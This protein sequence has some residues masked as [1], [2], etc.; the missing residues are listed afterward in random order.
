VDNVLAAHHARKT[1]T[2]LARESS[3]L[4]DRTDNG[5]VG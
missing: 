4:I 1:M 3:E 5:V 2:V